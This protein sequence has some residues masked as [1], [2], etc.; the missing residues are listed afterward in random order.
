MKKLLLLVLACAGC[1][2]PETT[3]VLSIEQKTLRADPVIR[4]EI[5]AK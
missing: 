2:A 5:R 1:K 3:A 4:F